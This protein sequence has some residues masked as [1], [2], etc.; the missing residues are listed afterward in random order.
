MQFTSPTDQLYW[1]LLLSRLQ[2]KQ[3]KPRKGKPMTPPSQW[4]LEHWAEV[5]RYLDGKPNRA[6]AAPFP[7]DPPMSYPLLS[8]MARFKL[9]RQRFIP[10]RFAP[11]RFASDMSAR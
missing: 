6:I 2:A 1:L 10:S 5:C 8:N 11:A 7:D 4:Q 9:V 3:K